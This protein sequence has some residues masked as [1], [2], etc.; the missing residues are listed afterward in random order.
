MIFNLGG[1]SFEDSAE[2]LRVRVDIRDLGRNGKDRINLDGHRQ[3][4]AAAIVDITANRRDFNTAL[5]LAHGALR[6]IAVVDH[7][8]ADEA[9]AD[10]QKPE[11]KKS[12]KDKKAFIG[13]CAFL[14]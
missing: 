1:I 7:L 9:A 12:G 10:Q 11:G 4:V 6:V 5:L 2:N 14:G 13:V 3:L 8:K